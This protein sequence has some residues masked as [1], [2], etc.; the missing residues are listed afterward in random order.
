MKL[1]RLG[2]GPEIFHS[3]QGEGLHQGRPSVFVRTSRCNLYCSWC[4]TPYTWNWS[5]A[6][7]ASDSGR[8]Y[9][10]AEETVDLDVRDVA[11]RVTRWPC[12]N[13]VLTGGEPLL[14]A[15][16]CERLCRILR[17]FDPRYEFDVETNG[18]LMP[19][20]WMLEHV[21]LFSVSP[22]LSHSGVPR[23]LRL[24]P[25]VLRA[26][27]RSPRSAFKLVVRSSEDLEEIREIVRDCEIDPDRVQL[28]PEG[29]RASDVAARR[30]T[31]AQ[32]CQGGGYRYTDR[33]HLMLYDGRRGT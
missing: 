10:R 15:R 11:R 21:S 1:A 28:M 9:S 27:A 33:L 7:F 29:A 12:K 32:L 23:R 24:R 3:L 14:Q 2:E 31:V 17:S 6:A 26:F 30:A 13:V 22:K 19:T 4:D 20:D 25:E 18:T 16:D 5:D 8:K